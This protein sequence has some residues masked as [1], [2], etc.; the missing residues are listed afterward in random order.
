MSERLDMNETGWRDRAECA[1][2]PVEWWFPT[3]HQGYRHEAGAAE[4]ICS[5][6]PVA[7]ECLLAGQ[8]ESDGVWGG[9]FKSRRPNRKTKPV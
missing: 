4:A 7:T 3:R 8:N 2:W 1:G 9:Q 5:Q 6:C